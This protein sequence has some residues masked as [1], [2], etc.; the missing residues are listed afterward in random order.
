[1][2]ILFVVSSLGM[3]GEQKV[4]TLLSNKMSQ[5]GHEITI[6][7]LVN[8]KAEFKLNSSVQILDAIDNSGDAGFKNMSRIF[9]LRRLM[10]AQKP[11]VVIAFAVI[12]GILCSFAG[13]NTAKVIVCERNDPDIYSK[14][15]KAARRIAYPFAAGAV[16]QTRDAKAYFADWLKCPS[17]VIENPLDIK[18]LPEQSSGKRRKEIV[19]GGRLMPQKNFQLLINSFAEIS[20]R[21]PE[22]KL[23]IYGNGPA[24]DKLND[25]IKEKNLEQQAALKPAVAD[26]P[27][28]IK[29]AEIF[30]LPSNH[31]GF[32]NILA[33]AMAVGLP[34]IATDCPVGGPREM[35]NNGENGLLI[36]VGD[37]EAL[38][39]ALIKY[40]DDP[41]LRAGCACNAYS[42]RERLE[43]SN[44]TNK[45]LKYIKSL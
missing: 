4:V 34:V 8:S 20:S 19:A 18:A 25:L 31:E 2:K 12:P 40:L 28:E 33:E 41:L 35:I 29:D 26:F 23:A 10:K 7:T 39:A 6:Q 17:V 16:F 14:I 24:Y 9:K 15:Y 44:I 21:Y 37:E 30:V 13:I 45:W 36:G 43:V 32:P 27:R 38:K 3:G 22:Y 1:M 5:L 42:V 11:D